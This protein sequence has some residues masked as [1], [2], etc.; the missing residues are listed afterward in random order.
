M[1]I[2]MDNM[3]KKRTRPRRPSTPGFKA[4]IVEVCQLGD[5]T[6]RQFRVN[7]FPFIAAEQVGKHNMKRPCKLLEVSPSAYHQRVPA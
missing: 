1:S 2:I 6:V 3:G 5:H 4:G 7:A